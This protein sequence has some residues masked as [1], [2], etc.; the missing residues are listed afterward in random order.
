V[1]ARI[2]QLARQAE[3]R[4][5]IVDFHERRA[6]DQQA[7][8]NALLLEVIAVL[9]SILSEPRHAGKQPGRHHAAGM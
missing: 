1:A 2:R 9:A 8:V 4:R 7:R 6:A 3:H 5:A